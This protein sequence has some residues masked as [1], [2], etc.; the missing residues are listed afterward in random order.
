MEVRVGAIELLPQPMA[1]MRAGTM[2][3]LRDWNAYFWK[4]I[5]PS[6]ALGPGRVVGCELPL[7]VSKQAQRFFT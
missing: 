1:N 6:P 5:G 2:K 7:L 4:F 3:N